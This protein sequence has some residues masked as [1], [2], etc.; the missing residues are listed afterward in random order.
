MRKA[1]G[2]RKSPGEKIV[3]GIKRATRK[4]YSSEEK[5]RVV[6]DG[7]RGEA[8]RQD[9]SAQSMSGTEFQPR[10]HDTVGIC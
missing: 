7:L 5:F 1:T 6:L 3:K 9:L 8:G 4:H 10:W 2:M